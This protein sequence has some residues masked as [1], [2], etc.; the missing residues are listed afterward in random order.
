MISFQGKVVLVTGGARG[1]GKAI[2]T[3]FSEAGAMVGFTYK[4]SVDAAGKLVN[5]L[6]GK[7][8][9]VYAYQSDAA[10]FTESVKVV[11]SVL[12]DCG[13]LDILVNNAGITKDGLL[14]R[15]TEEDWETV[16]ATNLKS[17]FNFSKAA[18]RPMIS[19]RSGKIINISSIAGVTG[20]AGQ[21][22]YASSKAGMIGFPRT[23]RAT[24]T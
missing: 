22:N 6:T 10:S 20:N 4:S 16:I 17:V 7:G 2:V 11:E 14:M 3:S 1:I 18:S 8:G 13:R 12:R 5:E 9:R 21:T 24:V 23:I 19:Q 15:M